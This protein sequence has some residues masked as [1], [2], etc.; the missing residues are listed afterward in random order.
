VGELTPEPQDGARD[1]LVAQCL[2]N[3][4][5]DVD[6]R[7]MRALGENVGL[8]GRSPSIRALFGQLISMGA[9]PER[10]FPVA[11]AVPAGE[12][13][14]LRTVSAEFLRLHAAGVADRFAIGLRTDQAE[15]AIPILEAELGD[16]DLE[17][18]VVVDPHPEEL[19]QPGCLEVV[20]GA[21]PGTGR[22]ERHVAAPPPQ[23]AERRRRPRKR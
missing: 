22:A 3:T 9:A 10:R 4:H 18:D 7:R 15:A 8:A 5:P 21:H 23:L 12:P 1:L 16:A 19:V 14:A 17:I 20:V 13:E 6:M 11:V 2:R